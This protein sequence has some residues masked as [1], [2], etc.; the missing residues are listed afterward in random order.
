MTHDEFVKLL[1]EQQA[2]QDVVCVSGQKPRKPSKPRN[3]PSTVKKIE[4]LKATAKPAAC[5]PEAKNSVV[6]PVKLKTALDKLQEKFQQDENFGEACS[7]SLLENSL[8]TGPS[9]DSDDKSEPV[10]TTYSTDFS[11][12]MSTMKLTPLTKITIS[13]NTT[14]P[15]VPR[16]ADLQ[17]IEP[18]V[19][20]SIMQGLSIP[21]MKSKPV[22]QTKNSV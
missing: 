7:N 16:Q 19:E 9:E 8:V 11:S 12:H 1:C 21:W 2:V 3:V 5:P 18:I 13:S 14:S 20:K 22:K 17:L 10:E 6:E 4:T 15:V